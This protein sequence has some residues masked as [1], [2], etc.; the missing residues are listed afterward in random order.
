MI[1]RRTCYV[2]TLALIYVACII[3]PVRTAMGQGT[4]FTYQGHL[5]CNGTPANGIY[6]FSFSLFA[7]NTD[8]V[9]VAGPVTNNAVLVT[10]GQFT[11]PI[12]FGNGAF[13]G[14]TSWLEIAVESGNATNFTTLIPRQNLT[15]TPYAIYAESANGASISNLNIST[16]SGTLPLGSLPSPVVTNGPSGVTL[17]GLTATNYSYVGRWITN[18]CTISAND[19]ILF[20]WGTNE[21]LTLPTSAPFTKMFTIFSKNPNGSVILT[22]GTGSQTITAPGIGQVLAVYLGGANS[23][24]NMVTVMF[25]GSNY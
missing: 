5:H 17:S 20:C 2:L 24:S 13:I 12:D 4:A 8:G 23:P 22:N 16:A 3:F 10:N 7:T 14:S 19:T 9:P 1:K 15:P 25:D 18:S 11:V 6:N 21:V